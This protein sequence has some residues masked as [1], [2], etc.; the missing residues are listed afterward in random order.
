MPYNQEDPQIIIPKPNSYHNNLTINA[1][2]TIN[3]QER[4]I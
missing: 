4:V 2:P 1:E 3:Y